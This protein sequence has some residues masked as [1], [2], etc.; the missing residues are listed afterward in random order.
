MVNQVAIN[1]GELSFAPFKSAPN[2]RIPR[3]FDSAKGIWAYSVVGYSGSFV[4][5]AASEKIV[6]NSHLNTATATTAKY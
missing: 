1:L 6:Y 3:D 4:K 5:I 2:A